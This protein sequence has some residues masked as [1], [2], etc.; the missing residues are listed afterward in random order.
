MT[1]SNSP[2]ARFLPEPLQGRPK[3]ARHV[4]AGKGS[5]G[6][7]R[8]RSAAAKRQT[9]GFSRWR[10]RRR[11][12][13]AGAQAVGRSA[14]KRMI[15]IHDHKAGATFAVKVHLRAKKNA[16][17][18]ILGD[19]LKLSLTAPPAQGR[20]NHAVI[21]FLAGILRLPRS[22]ITI[23]A[24]HTSRNKVVRVSGL[25][26]STVAERLAAALD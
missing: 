12:E 11:R 23:A 19:A 3:V 10:E 25:S 9:T 13:A 21:E 18:G 22:S 7:A 17:T 20:A 15:P 8:N 14:Y 24:G 4:S 26:A 6:E 5:A 1:R 16:I 2:A